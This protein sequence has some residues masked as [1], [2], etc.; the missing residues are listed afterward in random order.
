MPPTVLLPIDF[1]PSRNEE[2]WPLPLLAALADLSAITA[3]DA[4][5]PSPFRFQDA[6]DML[7]RRCEDRRGQIALI[8]DGYIGV[9]EALNV[10]DV[11][12]VIE[13]MGGRRDE[14]RQHV[15]APVANAPN[16]TGKGSVISITSRTAGG[17]TANASGLS[18]AAGP[19]PHSINRFL[20]QPTQSFS[21]LPGSPHST[22]I[23]TP[24]SNRSVAGPEIPDLQVSP[25]YPDTVTPHP[26]PSSIH[27]LSVDFSPTHVRP[28][29]P[30]YQPEDGTNWYN[31]GVNASYYQMPDPFSLMHAPKPPM[32]A[33]TPTFAN[34]YPSFSPMQAHHPLYP[35]CA[36]PV[37]A[38]MAPASVES[39]SLGAVENWSMAHQRPAA[40]P[41]RP[42][43]LRYSPPG[44]TYNTSGPRFDPVAARARLGSPG[45]SPTSPTFHP[46]ALYEPVC[47][48]SPA[49]R[50]TTPIV[51]AA[52]ASVRSASPAMRPT[53]TPVRPAPSAARPTSAHG[54]PIVIPRRIVERDRRYRNLQTELDG[55]EFQAQSKELRAKIHTLKRAMYDIEDERE[56]DDEEGK[57]A[58]RE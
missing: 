5:D 23:N 35:R 13:A 12:I 40:A 34:R 26:P 1:L 32:P 21:P 58:R 17:Q 18:V 42:A 4:A 56:D 8:G 19:Y 30:T 6:R 49:A 7:I 52:A 51:R 47:P 10:N 36:A 46:A 27:G 33:P 25:M 14:V 55:T 44:P 50:P 2:E 11:E 31:T 16:A 48:A 20:T 45:W 22:V 43:S 9:G 15:A 39:P 37:Y 29:T 57:R 38:R 24:S 53:S 41:T 3:A 28:Q 54:R